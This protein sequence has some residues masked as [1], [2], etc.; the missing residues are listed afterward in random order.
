MEWRLFATMA[1]AAGAETVSV[2][3]G[4]EPTVGDALDALIEAA[5]GLEERLYDGD[6]E[7][8]HHVR[9]LHEGEDPFTAGDGLSEP[10]EPGD[11]LALMPAVSGG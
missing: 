9:V 2:E 1:E 4:P 5:P 3:P 11:E 8:Y 7:I 10:V 6:G